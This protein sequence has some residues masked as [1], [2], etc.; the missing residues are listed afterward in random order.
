[1]RLYKLFREY[2][3]NPFVW[4]GLGSLVLVA[5]LLYVTFN[6]WIM[7]GYTRH[8]LTVEVPDVMNFS[9]EEAT[10]SLELAGLRAELIILRKPNLP[11]NVVIDQRPRPL[12]L[13]KPGR[14]VYVTVNSGDTTTVLVPRVVDYGIRQASNMLALNDLVI[15][16]IRPD[17]IPSPYKDIITEQSPEAGSRVSPGTLVD[18][19]YGTGL[20]DEMV[21]V[22]DVT[23]MSVKSARKFLLDR[24]LRSVVVGVSEEEVGEPLVL[25]Q[26]TDPGVSVPEGFEIRLYLAQPDQ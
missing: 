2:L 23:N 24:R 15:G 21:S 14:N 25:R 9:S 8:G 10:N 17:S 12:S 6:Y 1:L 18:L 13:V 26:G 11:R 4:V 16:E 22:P 19:R 20:G 5:G 7:P 3:S